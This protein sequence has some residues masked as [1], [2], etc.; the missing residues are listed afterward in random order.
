MESP[1]LVAYQQHHGSTFNIHSAHHRKSSLTSRSRR[2]GGVHKKTLTIMGQEFF[3]ISGIQ[4][5]SHTGFAIKRL[6]L[7]FQ[8]T[9]IAGEEDEW[10]SRRH[11]KNVDCIIQTNLKGSKDQ[12]VNYLQNLKKAHH[13]MNPHRLWI[14][15]VS[16]VTAEQEPLWRNASPHHYVQWLLQSSAWSRLRYLEYKE[17]PL[18][19]DNWDNH[20]RWYDQELVS[21]SRTTN[22]QNQS[23]GEQAVIHTWG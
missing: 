2:N 23:A 4:N 10:N 20:Q 15:S 13:G 17:A 5:L 16:G 6:K 22:R 3:V 19:I 18:C 7:S 11:Q 14:P 12:P 8:N 21:Q 9:L 1:G